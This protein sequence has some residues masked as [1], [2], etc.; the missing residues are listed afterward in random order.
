MSSILIYKLRYMSHAFRLYTYTSHVCDMLHAR[1][2]HTSITTRHHT[3]RPKNKLKF[4]RRSIKPNKKSHRTRTHQYLYKLHTF[5]QTKYTRTGQTDHINDSAN[6][7]SFL[8]F[9]VHF[10]CV[11]CS[12]TVAWELLYEENV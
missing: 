6:I 5:T 2:N 3:T 4:K 7:N 9:S 1:L 11:I 12:G 10:F 8:I